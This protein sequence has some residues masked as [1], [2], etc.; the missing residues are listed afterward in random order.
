M[1]EDCISNFEVS[2]VYEP[3]EQTLKSY[4]DSRLFSIR[5]A[6]K[7]KAAPIEHMVNEYCAWA[8]KACH[9][10]VNI[11]I[12]LNLHTTGTYA[13]NLE[14]FVIDKNE[15]VKFLIPAFHSLMRPLSALEFEA[16]MANLTAEGRWCYE[17]EP[18]DFSS[19]ENSMNSTR[20]LNYAAGVI[21][22]YV[23]F[24]EPPFGVQP[25]AKK[26]KSKEE[27]K[28]EVNASPTDKYHHY[29]IASIE[30]TV[31]NSVLYNRLDGSQAHVSKVVE[32]VMML[33]DVY[34]V[35][36]PADMQATFDP[37]LELLGYLETTLGIDSSK[38]DLEF[39]L[40][41]MEDHPLLIDSNDILQIKA[42]LPSNLTVICDNSKKFK[43]F[44]VLFDDMVI[45]D[46][47]RP[48]KGNSDTAERKKSTDWQW[49]A[50]NSSVG[51]VCKF[52][53]SERVWIEASFSSEFKPISIKLSE[54]EKKKHI[55]NTT[56]NSFLYD[57]YRITPIE[58][59]ID[60]WN[61]FLD[62]VD[63]KKSSDSQFM[64]MATAADIFDEYRQQSIFEVSDLSSEKS[65]LG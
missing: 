32:L 34:G 42:H 52:Y 10:V 22:F 6:S 47:Y 17:G 14:W 41:L 35:Q 27:S 1:T 28:W 49:S 48:Y 43:L 51:L 7:K 53:Y 3:F 63:K 65:R 62:N 8:L 55:K 58:N 44:Q 31:K 61:V 36:Q 13:L 20:I 19:N 45:M 2:L 56:F 38:S 29:D 12:L 60:K 4:V 18:K 39:F 37:L 21:I 50:N 54:D 16:V 33:G 24:G 30:H 57:T 40:K 9:A 5:E 23:L 46:F 64:A 11:A 59:L 26:H 25:A 15:N